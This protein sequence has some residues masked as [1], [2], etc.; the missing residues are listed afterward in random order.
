MSKAPARKKDA[1]NLLDD[2]HIANKICMELSIHAQIEVDIFYP[3]VREA[4]GDDDMMDEA[5]VLQ[6][7]PLRRVAGG[8]FHSALFPGSRR[9]SRQN[10]LAPLQMP[11][12]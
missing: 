7:K 2:D 5:D 4:T 11:R 10:A 3:P 9:Q 8:T 12:A 1:V 6:V